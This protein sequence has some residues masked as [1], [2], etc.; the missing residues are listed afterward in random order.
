[1]VQDGDEIVP[2]I[3]ALVTPGHT[4]GHLALV[5]ESDG[6]RLLCLSDIVLHPVHL[7]RP[8]WTGLVDLDPEQTVKTRRQIL[9]RAAV[10]HALVMAYHFPAPGLGQVVLEG[11]GWRW[12]PL[13]AAS[14]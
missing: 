3:Q 11:H 4:P 13:G 2:G 14:M 5:L 6:E 7:E 8:D 1:M 9:G 10:D 12:Q